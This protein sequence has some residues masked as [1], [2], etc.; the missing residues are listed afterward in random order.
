MVFVFSVLYAGEDAA[1]IGLAFG[2]RAQEAGS[3][4]HRLE[5]FGGTISLPSNI[6]GSIDV[7][8]TFSRHLR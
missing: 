3:R 7:I 5:K 6:I 8:P 4:K 2:A 1:D